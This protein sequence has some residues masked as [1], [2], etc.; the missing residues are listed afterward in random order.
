MSSIALFDIIYGFHCIIL[1]N[2]YFYLQY[3]QQK[4]KNLFQQNK[5]ITNKPYIC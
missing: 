5:W 1:T 2:F 4:K 3:F